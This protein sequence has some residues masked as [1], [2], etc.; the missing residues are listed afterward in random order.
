MVDDGDFFKGLITIKDIEKA[1]QHP[2][3]AKDD[4]AACGSAP[5]WASATMAS[6]ASRPAR[7]RRGR[8]LL[9]TAHG[10]SKGY[11]SSG[12]VSRFPYAEI[13]AGNVA[14]AEARRR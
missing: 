3:A 11:R 2:Y 5:R 1:Q 12:D 7:R 13:V 14:T 8:D 6:S 9:D 4:S 10:H